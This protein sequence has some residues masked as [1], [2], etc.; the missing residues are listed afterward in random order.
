[1][2]QNDH[3]DE[4]RLGLLEKCVID[5]GGQVDDKM[6]LYVREALLRLT[7]RGAPTV[8][9][10]ITSE[11]GS[12]EFGLDIYDLLRSYSGKKVGF[13]CGFA[14]SMAAIILQ[15]C[16]TRCCMRHAQIMIHHISK[17]SVSLDVLRDEK[18]LEKLKIDMESQQ[19]RI[20][21]I[22]SVRSGRKPDEII[23]E[24]KKE[25]NMSSEEAKAFG[26]I[27]EIVDSLP[28]KTDAN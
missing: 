17:S 4:L 19:T 24:C 22:L 5:L 13:V 10:Q 8:T 28:M 16:D 11:G 21:S 27:D 18:R 3:L 15:G 26:L 2:W 6:V 25:K 12:V 14:R 1:M 9:I 7:A 20:Y 23:A